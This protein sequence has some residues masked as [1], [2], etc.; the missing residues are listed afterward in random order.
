MS[1]SEQELNEFRAEVSAWMEVNN[2]RDPGFLL[3]QTFMEP[4]LYTTACKRGAQGRMSTE[5]LDHLQDADGVTTT[6]RD[7]LSGREFQVRSKYLIGADGGNSKVAEHI[8][9]PIEGKASRPGLSGRVYPAS[10]KP[11]REFAA[12]RGPAKAP[13]E[14]YARRC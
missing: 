8:A 10:T 12:R 13:A 14:L 11:I 9:T 7:R 6:L 1:V 4:I 5:Y 2:P 3:P